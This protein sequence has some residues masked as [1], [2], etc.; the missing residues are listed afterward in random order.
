MDDILAGLYSFID[1]TFEETVT[2]ADYDRV[3]ID[4]WETEF[5]CTVY[6]AVLEMIANGTTL[7]KAIC[8]VMNDKQLVKDFLEDA[9]SLAEFA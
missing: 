5:R 7:D 1:D 4:W 2:E 9:R 6:G 3:Y 8:I